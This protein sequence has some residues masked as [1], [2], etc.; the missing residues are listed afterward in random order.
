[1][2]EEG[3]LAGPFEVVP[4]EVFG[5]VGGLFHDPL[6]GFGVGGE[7]VRFELGEA[8][9]EV[10]EVSVAAEEEP[11][12]VEDAAFGAG[13]LV[14]LGAGWGEEEPDD[15][16]VEGEGEGD[17]LLGV[18]LPAPVAFDGPLDGRDAGFGELLAE[19]L[20]EQVGDVVLGPAA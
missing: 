10:V 19:V 12:E 7:R 1:E 4:G 11:D 15:R 2:G 5:E 8:G 20:G 9:P 3:F 14:L 17:E 13:E 18:E 6:A 16:E